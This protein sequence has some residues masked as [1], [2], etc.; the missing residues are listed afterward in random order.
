MGQES[1]KSSALRE[2]SVRLP[3]DPAEELSGGETG[4]LIEDYRGRGKPSRPL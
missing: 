3:I 1:R 4:I 2:G